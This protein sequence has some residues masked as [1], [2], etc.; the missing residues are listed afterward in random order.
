[1][2]IRVCISSSEMGLSLETQDRCLLFSI[3]LS[4]RSPHWLAHPQSKS[5]LPSRMW[6]RFESHHI[7]SAV[8]VRKEY[9]FIFFSPQFLKSNI[10][11]TLKVAT[12][13]WMR[14][15]AQIIHTELMCMLLAQCMVCITG[16]FEARNHPFQLCLRFDGNCFHSRFFV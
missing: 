16:L 13:R 6:P 11:L 14:R 2:S 12:L 10:L 8:C 15:A 9:R 7:S 5:R 1:M 4:A 3:P